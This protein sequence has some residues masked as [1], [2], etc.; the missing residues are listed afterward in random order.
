MR[1]LKPKFFHPLVPR[2]EIVAQ[3]LERTFPDGQWVEDAP[4]V[5]PLEGEAEVVEAPG[6]EPGTLEGS[7]PSSLSLIGS[8]KDSA[9]LVNALHEHVPPNGSVILGRL[10]SGRGAESEAAKVAEEQGFP[11]IYVDAEKGFENVN[12]EAVLSYDLTSP[13]LLLGNGTRVK[14]ARSWLGRAEWGREV[15]TLA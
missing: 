15:Y 9:A 2:E 12:V 1:L 3:T 6:C 13:V 4:P 5:D 11:V 10:P 8:T 14:Q 7:S